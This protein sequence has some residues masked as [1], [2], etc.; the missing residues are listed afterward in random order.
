MMS[1]P[2]HKP[3]FT[4]LEVVLAVALTAIIATMIASA[5]DYHL[6]QLTVRRTQIEEA[7]IARAVL[8]QIADDLRG[9]VVYRP[10]DFSTVEQLSDTFEGAEA[11]LA[12][13]ETIDEMEADEELDSTADSDLSS[14]SIAASVPGLFGNES[15]LQIDVSRIPRPEE[16]S[17]LTE[18]GDPSEIITLGDVKTI[19]YFTVSDPQQFAGSNLGQ[20]FGVATDEAAPSTGLARRIIDR[21]ESRWASENGLG[22]L[23]DQNMDVFAPEITAIQ[24]AYFDGLEWSTEWD[25]EQR[26][27]IPVAVE[28]TLVIL[29]ADKRQFKTRVEMQSTMAQLTTEDVYRL[30]VHLPSSDPEELAEFAAGETEDMESDAAMGGL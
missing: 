18:F 29:P 11:L 14:S 25:S 16:Y 24:F 2:R 21:A 1:L 28:I 4:L 7:Q 12:G 26:G 30:V 3:G 6:R 9:T 15:Q 13:E 27:G 5:I 20:N 23:I 22:A 19:S 17:L 8:K 10:A